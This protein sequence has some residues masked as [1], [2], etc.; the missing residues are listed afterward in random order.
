MTDL[1]LLRQFEPIVRYTDGEMFFPCPIDEF[2][3]GASLWMTDERGKDHLVVPAGELTVEKLATFDQLSTS[4]KQHL[5]YVEKPLNPARYQSWLRNPRR[6][7]FSSAGRLARVPLIARISDSIFDLSLAVRGVVPGGQTA[8]AWQM[9]QQEKLQLLQ[10]Q[11]VHT[12][13]LRKALQLRL[14]KVGEAEWGAPDAHI[15]HHVHPESPLPLQPR[16]SVQAS[17]ILRTRNIPRVRFRFSRRSFGRS[18]KSLQCLSKEKE[19]RNDSR[20]QRRRLGSYVSTG[21]C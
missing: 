11:L 19:A 4:H 17:L 18:D 13:R 21:V 2:V 8:A 12:V 20:L 1:Q 5:R 16:S 3:N 10:K 9:Y 15:H 6:E 7:R 14:D